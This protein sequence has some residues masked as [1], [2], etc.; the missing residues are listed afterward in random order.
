MLIKS[1]T[2]QEDTMLNQND[3]REKLL[4]LKGGVKNILRKF[5]HKTEENTSDQAD[6]VI[7]EK[8]Y[9]SSRPD[10][11]EFAPDKVATSPRTKAPL[12]DG[13][14]DA[15]NL[16]WDNEDASM[17]DKSYSFDEETTDADYDFEDDLDFEDESDRENRDE[18]QYK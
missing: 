1:R 17:Q 15:Q 3:I 12:S 10:L 9:Y 6:G 2:R 5:Q 13:S 11:H 14:T 16:V 4:G 18:S 7:D 8:K